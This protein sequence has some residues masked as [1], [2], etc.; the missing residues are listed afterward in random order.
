MPECDVPIIYHT[1]AGAPHR[2]A[3][4]HTLTHS[5]AYMPSVTILVGTCIQLNVIKSISQIVAE[6]CSIFW[7][8]GPPTSLLGDLER[9]SRSH[10]DDGGR[11]GSTLTSSADVTLFFSAAPRLLFPSSLIPFC[12]SPLLLVL[13]QTI[14]RIRSGPVDDIVIDARD[15]NQGRGRPATAKIWN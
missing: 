4:T 2:R 3:Y 8:P 9:I 5:H 10:G 15:R 7:C 11:R 14:F 6:P 1:H 13:R 12:S